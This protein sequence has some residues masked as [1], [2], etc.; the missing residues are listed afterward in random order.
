MGSVLL[1]IPYLFS[2]GKRSGASRAPNTLF[3]WHVGAS[4]VGIFLV[5]LHAMVSLS[6]PPLALVFILFALLVS[7]FIGRVPMA[8]R[9]ATTFG[10]KT[11]PFLA[12]DPQVKSRLKEIIRRK[13]EVLSEL[14]PGASESLFSVTLGHWLR[15]PHGSWTY[16]RL[17]REESR[18][19]GA[20]QSV[21]RLQAWWRP[22]HLGLAWMFLAGLL[23]HI[24]L[25]LFFAGYV[26]DGGEI[27]WWHI[28]A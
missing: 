15:S 8:P 19:I 11:A 7:G 9:M 26:A 25:V 28:S 13:T 4:S 6:G 16:A 20:R 27:Y 3:V 1:L 23:L 24:V 12:S 5:M 18:L 21:S 22:L 14:D 10:N 17:A 2:L